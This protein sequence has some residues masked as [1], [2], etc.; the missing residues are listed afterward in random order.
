MAWNHTKKNKAKRK[1]KLMKAI[2]GASL[3]IVIILFLL[4]GLGGTFLYDSSEPFREFVDTLEGTALYESFEELRN[5]VNNLEIFDNQASAKPFI[6]PDGD[7]MALHFIDV[8][9]GDSTL[10]QTPKGN[11][12]ID[13]GEKEYGDDVVEYLKKQGIYELEYFII[14]HP[15]SDHMGCAAYILQNVKV[16]NFVI[17][18][19]EKSAA[20]FEN[21]LDVLETKKINSLIAAP[22]DVFIVGALHMQILGPHVD[23]INDLESNDSSLIIYATYG[24]K[25]FLFTGDAEKEGEEL[26][27]KYHKNDID[28]DIFSAGHHGAKTSN[29]LKLLQAATPEYVVVSCG[30]DNSYGHPTAEAMNNFASVGATVYRTDELGSIVFITDGTTLT[31]KK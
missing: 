11:V 21:A 27:L 24:S 6:D 8:G 31:L 26:L 30:K 14:T 9:Q 3:P 17:N 19:K 10:M 22:G 16:N 7:E 12:L 20:F 1:K 29:S 15:D 5:F 2:F 18:G 25:T 13:C 23:D 4:L 28:C